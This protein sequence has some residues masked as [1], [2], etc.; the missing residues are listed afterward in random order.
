MGDISEPDVERVR[1]GG[2]TECCENERSAEER[3]VLQE[4]RHLGLPLFRVID[5]P[6][7]VHDRR[8]AQEEQR[9]NRC[10]DQWV[11]AKRDG[12]PAQDE[13]KTRQDDGEPRGRNALGFG[14]ATHSVEPREVTEPHEPEQD[15][16]Y[17]AAHQ[18]GEPTSC[19]LQRHQSSTS[20]CPPVSWTIWPVTPAFE[21][22]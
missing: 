15:A 11:D 18:K 21:S 4:V 2:A 8:H 14:V 16:E 10:S 19:S 22:R 9:D 3:G 17:H 12:E 20:G 5:R 1:P 7:V 13:H 6:E